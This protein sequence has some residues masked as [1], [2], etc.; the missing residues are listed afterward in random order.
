MRAGFVL[1]LAL[2]LGACGPKSPALTPEQIAARAAAAAPADAR[3]AGLYA[4][5]C[6]NC[7]GQPGAGAPLA[8]DQA[9]WDGRWAKG[10]QTLLDHTIS[11]FNGMPAGGQCFSCSAD[12]YRALIRFMAGREE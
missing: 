5:A 8:L 12:D 10:E 2:A 11:G 1:V 4:G 6:R 3:L 9:A 7:H